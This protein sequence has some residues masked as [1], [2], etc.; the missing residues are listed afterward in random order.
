MI[1][2]EKVGKTR[3]ILKL[4]NLHLTGDVYGVDVPQGHGLGGPRRNA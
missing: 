1:S 3:D 4:Q 2:M